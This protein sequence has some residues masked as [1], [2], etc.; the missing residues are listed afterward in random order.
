MPNPLPPLSG[1]RSLELFFQGHASAAALEIGCVM[2]ALL[3]SPS[4]YIDL[5]FVTLGKQQQQQPQQPT[6]AGY[7]NGTSQVRYYKGLPDSEMMCVCIVSAPG[8]LSSGS[9]RAL[10]QF[11]KKGKTGSPRWTISLDWGCP[12]SASY[13][14]RETHT[15]H[16]TTS[17]LWP[18]W[19]S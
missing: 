10:S 19:V 15:H 1:A 9:I 2:R 7:V 4:L 16:G 13:P 6:S 5:F 12:S 3:M 17:L 18:S 8:Q 11:S 14:M